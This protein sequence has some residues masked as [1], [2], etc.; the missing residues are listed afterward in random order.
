MERQLFE[1]RQ[2]AE[3]RIETNADSAAKDA[4]T[5][6][7]GRVAAEAA[8]VEASVSPSPMCAVVLLL[9][10][11]Q[12][13]NQRYGREVG[14]KTLRF[15][16]ELLQRTFSSESTL[17]RWAG[18]ALLMLRNGPVDKVQPEVRRVLESRI[19]YDCET[20][21]RHLLLSIDASWWVLPMMVDARLMINKIDSLTGN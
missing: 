4:I 18:P 2:E 8:L 16:A 10:R 14:D 15:F 7:R 9:D 5:D 13:Y 11:L 12:L 1:I 19:Q 20:G 21:S 6:L 3:R 17:F